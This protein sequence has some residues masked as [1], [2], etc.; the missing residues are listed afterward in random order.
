[1]NKLTEGLRILQILVESAGGSI[2]PVRQLLQRN[3][4]DLTARDDIAQL[5]VLF[6]AAI[7]GFFHCAARNVTFTDVS[8][9]QEFYGHLASEIAQ[10]TKKMGQ[11]SRI[12]EFYGYTLEENYP[13]ASPTFMKLARTYW[14]FKVILNEMVLNNRST[15]D[16]SVCLD[17]LQAIDINFAG[18]F[19][20]TPGPFGRP[21]KLREKTM[22]ALIEQSG[23]DLDVEDYIRGNFYLR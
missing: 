4:E 19:F 17:L 1:M 22:R 16:R 14:T 21:K 11:V 23:A 9:I 5:K 7:D 2:E 18:V 6:E 12:Q 10:A 3:H 8:R 15:P 13:G 20:P